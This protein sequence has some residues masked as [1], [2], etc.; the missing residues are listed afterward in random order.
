[1][2]VP[3]NNTT[4]SSTNGSLTAVSLQL[5][6]NSQQARVVLTGTYTGVTGTIDV[7]M[8]GSTWLNVQ[9]I[10]E[11]VTG[12]SPTAGTLSPSAA[13]KSYILSVDGW[14]YVR[15][16]P[17]A[18]ATGTLN[19]AVYAAAN[20]GLNVPI[21][22]S[23]SVTSFTNGTFSGTLD[24]SGAAT[25]G[26]TVAVTGAA[27][28][29]STL[30]VTGTS[31]LTGAVTTGSTISAGGK[32]FPTSDD[33]AALGDTTHNFSDLFLASGA[34]VNYANSNVVITHTSGI[35][36]MGTG[37]FRVTT[38]G[39]NSASVVTVG[40]TQTLTNKTLTSPTMTAPVLGVATGTSLAVSGLL[41]SSS[42]SAGIGYATGAGTTVSQGTS[43]TTGVTINAVC[44]QITLVSAAGSATPSTFTV[45][46][47][48]VAAGDTIIVNQKSGTDKYIISV[49][50]VGAGSF[51]I[52]N[53]TTG[54]TTTETPVFTFAVIKAVAA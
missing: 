12:G 26:S 35:L 38:A 2:A 4:G 5:A 1:M 49:T 52:T 11:T 28:L 18:V 39:T 27:T 17:T 19:I 36:T 53:Y 51:A 45:T 8:D 54:G 43:R 3:A 29:S 10:D 47:S 9:S 37:D 6:P 41:T 22:L 13:N 24:V 25:F 15:F 50:A 46:N 20:L 34:V 44:G 42:A 40:G 16:L 32:V 48:A 30:A 7:S 23:S 14:A 31:T 21:Q 33:G